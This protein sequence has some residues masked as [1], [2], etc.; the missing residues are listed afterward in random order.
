VAPHVCVEIRHQ[1]GAGRARA[2]KLRM[3]QHVHAVYHRLPTHCHWQP[4]H[5]LQHCRPRRWHYWGMRKFITV[6]SVEWHQWPRF[7]VRYNGQC[8]IPFKKKSVMSSEFLILLDFEI[9]TVRRRKS[10]MVLQVLVS[11]LELMVLTL[12]SAL[13]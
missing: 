8:R 10:G 9:K 6:G 2:D 7:L 12:M 13:L 3:V 5:H 4:Q 11:L 1:D